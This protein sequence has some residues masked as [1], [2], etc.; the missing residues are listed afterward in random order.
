MQVLIYCNACPNSIPLL[1]QKVVRYWR[2]D[3]FR[4]CIVTNTPL[5]V[6]PIMALHFPV[7]RVRFITTAAVQS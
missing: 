6:V 5:K 2:W 4:F 1:H 3:A 7:L